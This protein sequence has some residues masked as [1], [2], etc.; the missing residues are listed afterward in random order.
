MQVV[1]HAEQLAPYLLTSERM[2]AFTGAGISVVSG[3]P[4]FTSRWRGEP[5]LHWLSIERLRDD[6]SSFYEFF[7]SEVV[8]WPTAQPNAA[9]FALAQLGCPIVTQ[10]YD[11]LHQK[12]GSPYVLELHG[13]PAQLRCDGCAL[14]FA[15][16]HFAQLPWPCCPYC[17]QLLR[18]NIVLAGEPAMHW[19]EAVRIVE[20][21][22]LLLVIGTSLD[23]RP[24]R[25]L[26]QLAE[27]AGANVVVIN[28]QA[29][30]VLP[31]GLEISRSIS[32]N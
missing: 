21:C 5:I 28:R 4:L 31:R 2:A 18:P 19:Q 17:R 8:H 32:M 6:P 29:E 3:L 1:T 26:P 22:D 14:L 30:I 25:G 12:A 7:W 11:G 13:N 9:H 27:R 10:N 15:S 20:S 23:F 16:E 24:A